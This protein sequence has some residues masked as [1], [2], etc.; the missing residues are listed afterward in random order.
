MDPWSVCRRI[1]FTRSINTAEASPSGL[2]PSADLSTSPVTDPRDSMADDVQYSS[3]MAARHGMVGPADLWEMKRRFQIEYLRSVGLLPHHQLLDLGCG[4][5]RGGIPLI[6]YL[7]VGHYTGVDVRA[8]ALEEGCR[9]IEEAGLVGRQPQIFCCEDLRE[10][11]AGKRFDVIWAFA[12]LIHMSDSVLDGALEA[13]ARHLEPAGIFY[14]SVNIDERPEG[15]WQGFPIV[16]R[17]MSFYQEAVAR[18][19]L[20]LEDLGSLNSLGHIHPRLSEKMQACQRMLR[21]SHLPNPLATVSNV[22]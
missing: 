20:M 21:I 7:D 13:V 19:G 16:S 3:R 15:T 8:A 1:G 18:H 22:L 6:Q 14:A 9:E 12:V 2:W 11:Q 17:V 4:T 5:M 10:F